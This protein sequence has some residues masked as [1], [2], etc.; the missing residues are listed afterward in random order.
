[1]TFIDDKYNFMKIKTN[2]ESG[3]LMHITSLPGP[4]GIGSMGENARRFVDFLKASGQTYWQVLP[5]GPTGYGDSPYASF[6]SF[7]GN[8]Y[9]IDLDYLKNEGL[10]TDDELWELNENVDENSVD[11]ARIYSERQKVLEKAFE[12]FDQSDPKYQEFIVEYEFWLN[13]YALFMSIKDETDKR[14]WL[15]WDDGYKFRDRET[16]IA[17]TE[18]YYHR[19]DYHK[20]VQY[21]FFSQWESLKQYANNQGIKIMGDLPIYVAEDSVDTWSKPELFLLDKE[22]RPTLVGGVPPDAFT[23]DGQLWGNP[24]Y[25]WDYHESTDYK[26]W[27]ERIWWNISIFDSVRIDHFRGF[28]SFWAVPSEDDTARNGRW[29]EGPGNKLFGKAKDVL[30]PLPIIAEDLGYMTKEVYEFREATGFP[31]MNILQFAFNEAANSDYLPHNMEENS[32][33]YTGTHD[34]DTIMGWLSDVRHEDLEIARSYLNLTHEEG[35]IWGLIRG[36]MTSVAR[37]AIFQMQDLLGLG[38]E[39]RMNNPGQLG[40]NWQWRMLDGQIT[41]ELIGRFREMTRISGRIY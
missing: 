27:I 22:L 36:A 30:G 32:V 2:R 17:F 9:L 4:Y 8:P 16:I 39:A 28:E 31:G 19:I 11:F 34:N 14:S 29:M 18:K 35:Y 40:N 26:W 23:D 3:V 10:L 37:I 5:I 24:V 33:V 25:D 21:T 20:F 13:D 6:S 41:D 15:E 7:A 38:S 1:M 12:R